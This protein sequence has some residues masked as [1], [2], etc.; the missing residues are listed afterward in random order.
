[1]DTWIALPALLI[2]PPC[3]YPDALLSGLTHS[4]MHGWMW[5]E[6]AWASWKTAFLREERTLWLECR[7]DRRS[8]EI[9]WWGSVARAMPAH[10]MSLR[11]EIWAHKNYIFP[12]H[13][14][15]R[16]VANMWWKTSCLKIQKHSKFGHFWIKAINIGAT[17]ET[18]FAGE[19]R[20]EGRLRYALWSV[21]DGMEWDR[22]KAISRNT[23]RALSIRVGATSK[24]FRFMILPL[25]E[26][27]RCCL[28]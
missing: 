6:R 28:S 23:R 20:E 21:D 15:L 14:P 8:R 10:Q 22:H 11:M 19:E 17:Q 26:L 1:M 9:S 3:V 13:L 27:T 2:F 5:T 24:K 25:G 12:Q 18:P 7:S 4:R 16:Y